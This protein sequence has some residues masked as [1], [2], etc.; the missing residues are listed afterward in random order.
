[1]RDEREI[2]RVLSETSAPNVTETG[3]RTR[4]RSGLLGAAQQHGATPRWKRKIAWACCA[5]VLVAAGAGGVEAVR[6]MLTFRFEEKASRSWTRPDGETMSVIVGRITE[7]GS[8]DPDFTEEKARQRYEEMQE[9]IEQ[10]EYELLKVVERDDGGKV[11]IYEF[12]F[13][14]GEVHRLGTGERLEDRKSVEDAVDDLVTVERRHLVAEAIAEGRVEL[15]EV[16]P[17]ESGLKVYLYRITLSDGRSMTLGRNE[18]FDLP[19][20][21][22]DEAAHTE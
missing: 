19:D 8:D 9:L 3:H 20:S 5:I 14:D 4:L 12:V 1:M 2:E 7:M 22:E 10:G 16:R 15:I 17:L 6:R 11:Y 18:P 21:S 13:S